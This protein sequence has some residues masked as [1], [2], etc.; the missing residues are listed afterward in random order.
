MV[1][2]LLYL[3]MNNYI[4]RLCNIIRVSLQQVYISKQPMY[5]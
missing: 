3:Q 4:V 2:K 1:L 5:L